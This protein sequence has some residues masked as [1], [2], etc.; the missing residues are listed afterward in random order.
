MGWTFCREW[1][2]ESIR[3]ELNQLAEGYTLVRA[4]S[5]GGAYW[6][7]IRKPDGA[8]VIVCNLIKRESGE[9]GVKTM[10][11]GMGPCNYACPL[12]ILA[13]ATEPPPVGFAAEWREKVRA[14]HA[15]RKAKREPETGMRVTYCG[16]EYRLHTPAGPRKGWYVTNAAGAM[17]RMRAHQLSQ[18]LMGA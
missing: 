14:Y 4:S 2:P 13:A 7:A 1:T 9:W 11:E 18:A 8:V 17:F 12:S 10:D 5:A 3:A 6:Q 16:H 15:A